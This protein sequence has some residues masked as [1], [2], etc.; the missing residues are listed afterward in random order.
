MPGF[1]FASSRSRSGR[2][3]LLHV[4]EFDGVGERTQRWLASAQLGVFH[5]GVEVCGFEYSFSDAGVFRTRPKC[6]QGARY[7]ETVVLGNFEGSANDVDG[8]VSELQRTFCPGAYH[9]IQLNCNHFSD[10]FARKL[11]GTGIPAHLNRAA[12]LGKRFLPTGKDFQ[13]QGT[14][15]G[16]SSPRPD[17]PQKNTWSSFFA[18]IWGDE[19]QQEKNNT[20]TQQQKKEL[21]A[22]QKELLA[23]VRSG[24]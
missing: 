8:V 2:P 5:T 18:S 1:L 10:A 21:T 13:V 24:A 3:V 6:I 14:E 4:Y 7:R 22:K 15:G 19:Q 11:V 17:S 16:E 9:L 23:R 12:E 20:A